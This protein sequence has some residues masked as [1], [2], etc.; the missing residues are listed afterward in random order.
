M[1]NDFLIFYGFRTPNQLG[2]ISMNRNEKETNEF[3][4]YFPTLEIEKR[5]K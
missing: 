2:S 5:L 4:D 1:K 3:G